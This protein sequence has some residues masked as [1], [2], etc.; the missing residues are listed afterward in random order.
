M[1]ESVID[2]LFYLF[3]DILADDNTADETDFEWVASSL[4]E[5]GFALEDIT[6]AMNWFYA[7][8]D[9][10]CCSP[11]VGQ[12]AIRVFS[13]REAAFLNAE[14]QNF[15]YGLQRNG[16]INS[17][18]FEMIV[19]RALALEEP[20]DMEALRWVALM[21]ML[22]AKPQAEENPLTSAWREQWLYIDDS[23]MLQ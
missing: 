11:C 21:V 16:V 20:L 2:V 10:Q 1:R 14:C 19:E 5:A 23:T 7:F 4:E 17:V 6:R 15:L 18:M 13:A 12:H 8:S 3:D 22:N 9:L